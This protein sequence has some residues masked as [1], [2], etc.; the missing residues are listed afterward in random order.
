[1]RSPDYTRVSALLPSLYQDNVASFTQVDAF[2]GLADELAHAHL[3][4]LEDLALQV[5]PDALLRWPAEVPLEAG[6]DDLLASYAATYD[7]VASWLGFDF[8]PGWL[9]TEPGLVKRREVLAR[10]TRLWR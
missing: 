6:A 2:L 1:M 8:P 5:S 9:A 3:E 10:M 4:R 7:V